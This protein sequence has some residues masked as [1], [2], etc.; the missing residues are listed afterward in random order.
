MFGGDPEFPSPRPQETRRQ[1][2]TGKSVEGEGEAGPGSHR[3]TRML[4]PL[5]PTRP[6]SSFPA[7]P[8]AWLALKRIPEQS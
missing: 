8:K 3:A 2:F 4:Q 6:T 7:A 1:G 5:H